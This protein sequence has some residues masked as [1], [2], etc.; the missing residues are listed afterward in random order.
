M[1]NKRYAKFIAALMLAIGLTMGS[2]VAVASE[3]TKA[4]MGDMPAEQEPKTGGGF[5]V[6][7]QLYGVGY[8][9]VLYDAQNGLPTSDANC[10]MADSNGYIWIGSY[11]GI[12]VYDGTTFRRLDS[13]AGFT[14]GK[15]IFQDKKGRVWV[16][17]NDN[18]VVMMDGSDIHRFTYKEGLPSS[19]IRSFA[20]DEEGTIY[21]AT[22]S[23]ICYVNEDLSITTMP[24][25]ELEN[26]YIN[27][28]FNLRCGVIVGSTRN[29]ELFTI[30]DRKI[31][32]FGA[33]DEF[34]FGHVTSVYAGDDSGDVIYVGNDQGQV[35]ETFPENDFKSYEIKNQYQVDDAL[36]VSWISQE[37]DTI[38]AVVD[39]TLYYFSYDDGKFYKVENLPMDSSIE[40]VESDYQGN[41]WMVSTRQGVAKIVTNNFQDIT[42]AADLEPEV[43]NS[44][45]INDG[46]LYIG[47]D[48]GLQIVDLKTMKPVENALTEFIGETRIRCIVS[49]GYDIWICCYNN[50]M[51]LIRYDV[52]DGSITS[53]TVENGFL[54]NATRCASI[55]DDGELLVGTNDGVVL[56][57]GDTIDYTITE[58]DGMDNTVCLTVSEG[59]DGEIFVGTDGGGMYKIKNGAV[60]NITRED[61]LTSDVILRVKKDEERGVN[62]IITS[63]SLQYMKS[64]VVYEIKNFPYSNNF[65]IYFDDGGNAWILSSNG[66]YCASADDLIQKENFEYRFYN[67][68]T[69]LTSTPTGNSFSAHESGDLYIAG[70]NGVNKVNINN[71][72]HQTEKIKVGIE[73][74]YINDEKLTPEEDGSYVI[75]STTGRIQINAAII[76]YTLSNPLVHMYLDGMD[77]SGI[78]ANQTN[79]SALEYTGLK[80]G[81]YKL[82]IEILDAST[83]EIYQSEVFN[84]TK[85]PKLTELTVFKVLLFALAATL[86]SIIIWRITTGTVIRRQYKEIQA[87]KAEAE[88]ANSVKSRFL[89]NMSHEIRTPIN[90]I[91][92]MDEMIVREDASDVPKSYHRSMMSYASDIRAASES[93]LSLIDDVLD[94]SRIESGRMKLIEQEYNTEDVIRGMVRMIRARS[95]QKGLTFGVDIDE[96]LPSVL[97]GD[98]GKIKQVVLNLLTNAV[99][100]T[101]HG[102]LVLKVTLEDRDGSNCR[103]CYSVKDTGI[104]IKQEDMDRVFEAFERLDEQQNSGIQGAGLGLDIS[105]QF[106]ELMKGELKCESVYGKG[107]EFTFRVNQRVIDATPLGKFNEHLSDYVKG[108]YKPQFVAPDAAVL[109]VDDNQMNL[110]V[111]KGLLASTKMFI[112]TATTGEECLEKLKE[113]TFNVVLLDHFMQGIDGIETVAKIRE[114]YPDLP[115]YAITANTEAGGE[116]FYISKGFDGYLTK[117]ID[118]LTLEKTIRKCLPDDI[119]ED[120]VK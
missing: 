111:I 75:P 31:K 64:G 68:N 98:V 108:P 13:S 21:I 67:Y 20:E 71:F 14:S 33:G 69:G 39:E 97:Y 54:S 113:S 43:V 17:T 30:E 109:V 72:Y 60:E 9:T 80:Y 45:A 65:D 4:E 101:K 1:K 22:T 62:W 100:Y 83:G 3:D 36:N 84:I 47:T 8:A 34:G 87:A 112:S 66:I 92:G 2:F 76:N 90:T 37:C 25:K 114:K 19:S 55:S 32:S 82:V 18:G 51:G 110:T 41:L 105:R 58:Q 104:G 38:W 91:I 12:I 49:Y 77:D 6:S 61:G 40:M 103:I 50:D 106:A 29:G 42:D 93:L 24:E 53:H 85:Q 26:T 57:R 28:I 59:L 118:T 120:M 52:K 7:G 23:G 99:K 117:P 48:K 46:V 89:A 10:I 16:G 95:D 15:A 78:T 35:F 63:N 11:S 116:E 44:T 96:G 27:R 79:L 81:D 56:M 5:A 70:R 119:V 115:V 73:S 94:L 86:V 74:I 102:G 88:R 107:S